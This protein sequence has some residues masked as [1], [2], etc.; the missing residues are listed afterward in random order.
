MRESID[1][2]GKTAVVTGGGRGLGRAMTLGLTQ[3]GAD[4]VAGDIDQEPLDEL[5]RVA[6]ELEASRT[7]G[8]L[9]T[10]RADISKE[11]DV[12]RLV[13]HTLTSYGRIDIVVNN[14]GIGPLTL[15]KSQEA[16]LPRF[17]EVPPDKYRLF[18]DVNALGTFL[19]VCAALP[20]MRRR[21]WGRVITVTTS[22]TSML[23]G[24]RMPYGPSKAANESQSS[25]MAAD[26]EGTGIT[27][28]VLV[29]GA[30]TD[31]RMVPTT[32]ETSRDELKRPEIMVPP[33]LW[34]ASDASNGVTGRRFVADLWQA[35]GPALENVIRSGAP[36]GWPGLQAARWT[37]L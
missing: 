2:T 33:L 31:T 7:T 22:L 12:E 11:G 36:I 15:R 24:R 26:L 30:P 19:V 32:P 6:I 13:D 28:N 14:A 10:C 25:V 16:P 21:G 34:L 8:R 9:A 1:L 37:N 5:R 23:V 4:V 35:D 29:P 20:E 18:F 17:W 3:A 27:V